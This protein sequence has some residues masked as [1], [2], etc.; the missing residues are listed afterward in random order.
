MNTITVLR[1]VPA[2]RPAM[3][4][5]ALLTAGI[6]AGCAAPEPLASADEPAYDAC[7]REAHMIAGVPIE[8][9]NEMFDEHAQ[10]AGEEAIEDARA[11]H[12]EESETGLAAWPEHALIIR[13][14]AARGVELTTA[15]AEVLARWES[16][17]ATETGDL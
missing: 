4:T 17:L 9:G 10:N 1:S 15:Q 12:R 6:V 5:I 13:C 16:R 3:L 2:V 7:E 8:R 14:L 11:A